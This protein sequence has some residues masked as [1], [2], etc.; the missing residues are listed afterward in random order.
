LQFLQLPL[1]SLGFLATILARAVQCRPGMTPHEL[2]QRTASFA[3]EVDAFAAPLLEKIRT[4]DKAL[5]LIRASGSTAA[6]YRSAGRARSHAEFTSR[7]A[8]AL[9]EAD[10]SQYWLQHLE[11]CGL[12]DRDRLAPL[13]AEAT[14]LVAIFTSAWKT[15]QNGDQ[16]RRDTPPPRKA[17]RRKDNPD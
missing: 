16:E 2:R 12:G 5:Q 3:K 8:V 6:N 15:A 14:E 11:A 17:K 4:R 13:L 7:L 9:E 10:E 1:D